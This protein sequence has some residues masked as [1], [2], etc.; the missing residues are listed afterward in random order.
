MGPADALF[1]T[2]TGYPMPVA[3]TSPQNMM[4]SPQ[5]VNAANQAQQRAMLQRQAASQAGNVM[6]NAPTQQ[7]KAAGYD[8]TGG[9]HLPANASSMAPLSAGDQAER[10]AAQ[11]LITRGLSEPLQEMP[12]YIAP[13]I[14]KLAPYIGAA[15]AGLAGAFL[16]GSGGASGYALPGA[17]QGFQTGYG[18]AQQKA[19][20]EYN[21][22]AAAVQEHNKAVETDIQRATAAQ[23][24]LDRYQTMQAHNQ[25]L[26][27]TLEERIRNDSAIMKL[28]SQKERDRMILGEKMIAAQLQ[29]AGMT[30]DTALQVAGLHLQGTMAGIA[31]RDWI[32]NMQNA[33]RNALGAQAHLDREDAVSVRR[34]GVTAQGYYDG[35]KSTQSA[36]T[37]LT[38]QAMLAPDQATRDKLIAGDGTAGNPGLAGLQ[39]RLA[40]Q[41]T[42]FQTFTQSQ[43]PQ[44]LAKGVKGGKPLGALSVPT[45]PDLSDVTQ[46]LDMAEAGLMSPYG[47]Y[48]PGYTAPAAAPAA[49]APAAA[50][51]AASGPTSITVPVSISGLGGNQTQGFNPQPF[52]DMARTWRDKYHMTPQAIGQKL[53]TSSEFQA[54]PIADK[55]AT[56]VAV[57][58]TLA[59]QQTTAAQPAPA[60]SVTTGTKPAVKSAAATPRVSVTTTGTTPTEDIGPAPAY[61]NVKQAAQWRTRREGEVALD[62]QAQ[63]IA[64]QYLTNP[65]TALDLARKMKEGPL[66]D[67]VIE[68]IQ[69]DPRTA[70][71]SSLMTGAG[72]YSQ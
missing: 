4:S 56:L 3:T 71:P 32:A 17:L 68:L 27:D 67:K 43:M 44:A 25:L 21:A 52:A 35:I 60:A 29:R 63:T 11:A 38:N 1:N 20:D 22:K 28:G 49:P 23:A 41:T 45:S 66:R 64:N 34:F 53:Q 46:Q 57:Q 16:K 18:M 14:S 36:I 65:K 61:M 72:Q 50:A 47:A 31:S 19:L 62:N 8:P 30:R 42:Q 12:Q 33:T 40:A 69:R 39:S 26:L 24:E 13:H 9:I 5:A 55:V 2:V 54:L 48:P 7:Q 6:R 58:S 70:V 37:A 10:N 59:S 51:P 15:I